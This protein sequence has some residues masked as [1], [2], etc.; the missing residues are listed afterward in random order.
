[1]RFFFNFQWKGIWN[2]GCKTA[3]SSL[4]KQSYNSFALNP[5]NHTVLNSKLFNKKWL[6]INEGMGIVIFGVKIDKI[7]KICFV[8]RFFTNCLS[9]QSS[10]EII[11]V[12]KLVLI[13]SIDLLKT[14]V[15]LLLH[16][17]QTAETSRPWL[18]M[19]QWGLC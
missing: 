12:W 3:L 14:R 17:H 18:E 19:D 6:N 1:M 5:L 16:N 2:V 11:F 10:H 4:V 15:R 13:R 9:F 7:D 8:A